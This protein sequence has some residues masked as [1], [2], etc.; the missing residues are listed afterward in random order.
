MGRFYPGGVATGIL[1]FF[2]SIGGVFATLWE[3]R[4]LINAAGRPVSGRIILAPQMAL[5]LYINL[6]KFGL[7]A[8]LTRAKFRRGMGALAGSATRPINHL[9]RPEKNSDFAGFQVQI[10]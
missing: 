6:A 10:Y 4:N 9:M 5:F 3:A 1:I 8:Y 2:S 7:A